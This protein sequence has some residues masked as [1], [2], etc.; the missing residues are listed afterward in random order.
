MEELTLE[1][2]QAIAIAEA[3]MAGSQDS[4]DQP[5]KND[6]MGFVNKGFA[7]GVL[8][9]IGDLPA[10]AMR[11]F[12]RERR[13]LKSGVEELLPFTK[14]QPAGTE[15]TLLGFP[16][17]EEKAPQ[18]PDE[19]FQ[20]P[21][22]GGESF[23]RGMANIGAPTPDREPQSPVENIGQAVG[24]NLGV[25]FPVSKGAQ[26]LSKA[27]TTTGRVANE[28]NQFLVQSPVKAMAVEGGASVGQGLA[29]SIAEDQEYGA[30]GSL[31]LE[32]GGSVLGGAATAL[33][34]TNLISGGV[35]KVLKPLSKAQSMD[36]AAAR[37]Q[38]VTDDIPLAVG[39]IDKNID[40][41]L[42]P[43]A[44]TEDP[45][46]MS[47]EQTIAAYDPALGTKLTKEASDTSDRLFKA[48]GED[49]NLGS[50][51]S[52]KKVLASN[53]KR[54]KATLDA[55][56]A[57]AGERS[58]KALE[59]LG[60][61][62]TEADISIIQ[63]R[64]LQSALDEANVD[65]KKLWEAIPMKAKTR[66][67]STISKYEEL[68]KELSLA[69]KGDMPTV[70]KQLLGGSKDP[71]MV[72][73]GVTDAQGNMIM[74]EGPAPTGRLGKETTLK[75]LNGLYK[76]LG[77]E[78][79]EARKASKNNTARIAEE[80]RAAILEDMKYVRGDKQARESV[81]KAREFSKQKNDKFSDGTI[82]K[83][84]G[85]KKGAVG[86]DEELTLRTGVGQMGLKGQLATEEI[87]K[88]TGQ[89]VEEL[90]A[91]QE[92]V[93]R[94]FLDKTLEDGV[95]NPTKARDFIANNSE[96]METYP[97]LKKQFESA[98]SAEDV[99]RSITKSSEALR[100]KLDN[101]A[102]SKTAAIL[103]APVHREVEVVFNSADPEASM[104]NI[105]NAIRRDKTGEAKL[106]LRA[107]VA[108]YLT[109]S[110]KAGTS[111]DVNGRPVISGSKLTALLS[112]SGSRGALAKVFSPKEMKDLDKMANTLVLL[113]RQQARSGVPASS[114]I[115]DKAGYISELLGKFIGV[116]GAS[117]ASKATGGGGS[118][119]IP[120]M[121]AQVGKKVVRALGADKAQQVLIDALT[122]DPQLL[123]ALYM[124]KTKANDIKFQKA[125]KSYLA[126][127]GSRLLVDETADMVEERV[128]GGDSPQASQ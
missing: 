87:G 7:K 31:A 53:V 75:E 79:S 77:T 40:T 9:A 63:R 52:T 112:N 11:Q 115:N 16:I 2:K 69:E 15:R 71:E 104:Q 89:N 10:A 119:Q 116:K 1:Q 4:G 13:K 21:F 61:V 47:M 108:E 96:L 38:D 29:R 51:A 118:I 46:V 91:V 41:G 88:A 82:G 107:G 126:R 111:L 37:L 83:I 35:K 23:R 5:V 127:S 17:G 84:L 85:T 114:I 33:S 48:I 36:R 24:E 44:M 70:A 97:H 19:M 121:G 58:R 32:I 57:I 94:R 65:E 72:P 123:K 14:D 54:T 101:K 113:N 78:A 64:E 20:D 43:L 18:N 86:V 110:I 125:W 22:G 124:R 49:A 92:F 80:L 93:K 117:A 99:N 120:A 12:E 56:I 102:V 90:G 60:D 45:G 59:D 67:Q 109:N 106:G 100:G 39:N 76:T 34:P 66:T 30:G 103:K 8:G 50:M 28:M 105:V 27:P 95:V 68:S 74:L 25:M 128:A 6:P 42:A 73:S 26:L 81:G 55:R 122:K 98:R 3:E 62:A